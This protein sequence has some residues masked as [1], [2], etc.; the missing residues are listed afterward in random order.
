MAEG[1]CSD[2][3]GVGGDVG[4][5]PEQARPAI[6]DHVAS[7]PSCAAYVS[8]VTTTREL[9]RRRGRARHPGGSGDH[10]PP[11]AEPDRPVSAEAL[12]SALLTRARLLDPLN[13][14]DLAQ[15]SL[16]VGLAL[17]RRDHHTRRVAELTG[18][19]HALA[20]A[21][22]RLDGRAEPVTEATAAARTRADS[23][24]DLDGDADGP[25]LFYPDLYYPDLTHGDVGVDGWMESANEWR[26]GVQ[27]AGP[28][29]VDETREVYEVLDAALGELPEPLGELLALVDLQGHDLS[30]SAESLGLDSRSATAALAR[31]RN[32]VRGRLA[33]YLSGAG[34]P[35][36]R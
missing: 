22:A 2:I 31:A 33:E 5:A 18:I 30:G 10:A 8:Q 28:E 3:V 13:A 21:Q 16:E 19:L 20:D 26:G 29:E 15:R 27:I 35:S 6:T 1:R 23:L 34:S 11:T 17:Q 14:E 25:E 9:L 32:H 12:R 7:C 4:L 36:T 24:E